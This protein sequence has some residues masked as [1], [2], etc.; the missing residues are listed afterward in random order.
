MPA[1]MRELRGDG[2]AKRLVLVTRRF[3]PLV[4]GAEMVM[5]NMA[6][7]FLRLG[8]R[9]VIVTAQ[10]EHDWPTEVVHREVTVLRLPNPAQRAW[11]TL[12]YMMSLS[13]WL[14]EHS[15][16]IDA[17]YVSMLKHDAYAA[18]GALHD[19]PVPVVLRA[20]GAGESGDCH[21]HETARF[22][23]RIR[24]RCRSARAV[25]A[26]SRAIADEML[27]AGF[28]AE[29]IHGIT[30]GVSIPLPVS[31]VQ[32]SAARVA[33][34]EVNPDLAVRESAAVVVYTGRLH[35]AKGLHELIRA[36]PHVLQSH[37]D[38]R[39]WLV[40]EGPERDRL[41]QTINDLEMR[42]FVS[43]PGAFDDVQ[44]VLQA[45][46]L[47]VLP[48]YEE[49]MS[50]A[51]LEAM[52]AGIPVVATDIPGNRA[53]ITPNVQGRLVPPRNVQALS[54][55][56]CAALADPHSAR[57]LAQAAREHVR[58]EFSLEKSARAHLALFDRLSQPAR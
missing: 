5:S 1:A 46:D 15:T 37:P 23:M 35:Q 49:G 16:A 34:A 10:W 18:L 30:N 6:T 51:L 43:M 48:S 11:G 42:P 19:S 25:V 47:Y 21:W 50:I 8:H 39:L 38:A 29:T 36:W 40:G 7:E 2:F 14:R 52:A 22:G 56:I 45:A 9:P 31:G 33:L 13:R 57:G 17:V 55:A 26:P 32:R 3:W 12:R 58:N 4:G 24:K 44:E 20:E 41:F 53:I 54:Q 28:S 27:K